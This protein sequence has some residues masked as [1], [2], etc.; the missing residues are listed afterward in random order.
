MREKIFQGHWA[1]RRPKS[2]LSLLVVACQYLHFTQ[3]GTDFSSWRVEIELPLFDQLHRRGTRDRLRHRHDRAHSIDTH[4]V[5]IRSALTKRAFVNNTI[6][7]TYHRTHSR[8][9]TICYRFR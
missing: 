4:R 5:T 9:C 3:M 8:D 6:G 2:R 1:Y 7:I